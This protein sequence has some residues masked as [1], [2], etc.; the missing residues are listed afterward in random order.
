M[1]E[2][3]TQFNTNR[4]GINGPGPG[5]YTTLYPYAPV[6]VVS[7][8]GLTAYM[9]WAALRPMTELEYEKAC[10]GTAAPV[11]N[12][13]AWGT[14]T[15]QGYDPVTGTPTAIRYTVINIAAT[16]E[17]IATNYNPAD[18]NAAWYYTGNTTHG[19]YGPLRAGIF[20]ANSGNTG[21]V[22][23][24]STYYGIMEMS[25]NVYEQAVTVGNADGRSYIGHPG[26]GRLSPLA[27]QNESWPTT[28]TGGVG[29]R[30][31]YYA[32]TAANTL[33]VADRSNA[34][35]QLLFGGAPGG[36]G[37]GVRTAP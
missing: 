12:E 11:K 31:G 5:Q 28:F 35:S 23:A 14:N 19:E 27:E 37:R 26:N 16:D 30:G 32:I 1:Q 15:L 8:E 6:G 34:T 24:G 25:G 17:S 9:D 36:G 22:T 7:W 10:R 20:A 29:F 4:S 33:M 3:T 18:G 2:F 13:F 21:R